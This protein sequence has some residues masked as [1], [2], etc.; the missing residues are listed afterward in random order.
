[1]LLLLVLYA[2]AVFN[3]NMMMLIQHGLICS[4][5]EQ[6]DKYT[7]GFIGIIYVCPRIIYA[8]MYVGACMEY[9]CIQSFSPRYLANILLCLS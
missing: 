9:L 6:V 8:Y 2:V 7:R 1:M 4:L 3:S 5:A